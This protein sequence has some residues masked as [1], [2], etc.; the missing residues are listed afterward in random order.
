MA[1]NMLIAGSALG[2]TQYG[3]YHTSYGDYEAV[4][5]QNGTTY[6][7]FRLVDMNHDGA[8]EVIAAHY[9]D[10]VVDV[11]EMD[12]S[13]N[14]LQKRDTVAI[15]G[16]I[17]DVDAA[18][19]DHD[20]DMDIA[21]AVRGSGLFVALNG[22]GPGDPWGGPWTVLHPDGQYGWQVGIADFN[23]DGNLDLFHGVDGG[24]VNMFY[25]MG[26]GAFAGGPSPAPP[27]G[28]DYRA[29]RGFT[30]IDVDNNGRPDLI[31]FPTERISGLS[32]GYLRV[33]L[34]SG[35][36]GSVVWSANVGPAYSFGAQANLQF[37][38][39]SVNCAADLNHDG[40]IDQVL[41]LDDGQVGILWGGS[42]ATGLTWTRQNLVTLGGGLDLLGHL[43]DVNDD[44]WIDFV[45]NGG[46][47]PGLRI[48]VN[49]QAG[50][51]AMEPVNVAEP[52][53]WYWKSVA[54][55]DVDADGLCD[56]AVVRKAGGFILLHKSIPNQPPVC[57]A[58][59]DQT[60]ECAGPLTPVLLDGTGSY[61]PDGDP[62]SYEWSVAGVTLDD[63]TSATPSGDFPPGP[64]MVTLT[65]TDQFGA[66]HTDDVVITVVDTTPPALVCTTDLGVLWPPNH[67]MREV[68]ICL[69]ITE[70]CSAPDDLTLTALVSS[71]EPDNAKG[72][73]HFTG[74]VDGQDGFT[75]PVP[76]ELEYDVVSGC[77]RGTVELRAECDG[78][79]NGRTYSIFTEVTDLAGNTSTASC[80]VVVP[81]DQRHKNNHKDC[82][83]KS[84]PDRH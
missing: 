83:P 8:N 29:G 45:I 55:G 56:L 48:F 80:V 34:N 65:V 31:G 82:P 63:P 39:Q 69:A 70:V 28:A 77:F 73:G 47:M 74:D 12:R 25:G 66:F 4:L 67:K 79:K 7:G 11:W 24:F 68:E 2:Q 30:A 50:G 52:L 20:G 1:L 59:P 54:G 46:F 14:L 42:D 32:Q 33:F 26:D 36:P 27:P 81:H 60:V 53:Y 51:F 5:Y 75:S 62:I 13:T 23:A 61:D 18:D 21:V 44:G 16:N 40:Y 6:T 49:D 9:S 19:F 15:G 57:D 10:G 76:I 17:H 58:G 3:T 64:T 22:A 72:D 41:I 35:T 43:A 38:R 37:V 78:R 84:H 71:S